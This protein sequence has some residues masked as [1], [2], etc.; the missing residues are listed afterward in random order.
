VFIVLKNKQYNGFFER[1]QPSLFK[2]LQTEKY[3]QQR[4]VTRVS[5]Q[6]LQHDQ[7]KILI[8]DNDIGYW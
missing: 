7:G 2:Y 4:Q 6:T 8:V 3:W 5:Q 1:K